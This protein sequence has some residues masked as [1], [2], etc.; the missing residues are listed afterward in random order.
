MSKLKKFIDGKTHIFNFRNLFFLIGD[1]ACYPT[2]QTQ[3]ANRID[4]VY[5]GSF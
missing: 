4:E 1:I 5:K 3:Y 2:V